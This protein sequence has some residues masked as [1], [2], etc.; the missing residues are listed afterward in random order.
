MKTKES[1]LDYQRRRKRGI[2]IFMTLEI[3]I[4]CVVMYVTH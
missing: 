4:F 3:V 2:T 1:D